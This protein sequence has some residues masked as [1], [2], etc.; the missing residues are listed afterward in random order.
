MDDKN[1]QPLTPDE[2]LPGPGEITPDEVEDSIRRHDPLRADLDDDEQ[3]DPHD[4]VNE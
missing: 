1:S 2:H 4:E 3:N